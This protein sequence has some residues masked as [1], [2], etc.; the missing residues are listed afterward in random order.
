VT[1][2]EYQMVFLKDTAASNETQASIRMAGA[3]A[4]RRGVMP[5]MLRKALMKFDGSL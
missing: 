2:N 4:T 1:L 5:A 3:V